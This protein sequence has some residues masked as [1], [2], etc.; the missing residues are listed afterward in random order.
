MQAQRAW[1]KGQRG[2]GTFEVDFFGEDLLG[3]EIDEQLLEVERMLELEALHA[4][5]V[6][7]NA[8]LLV[9]RVERATR[10][11]YEYSL[12]THNSRRAA[13][14]AKATT[15]SSRQVTGCRRPGEASSF[16]N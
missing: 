5:R 12:V 2:K 9:E 13:A 16:G 15:G 14:K 10:T 6:H 8:A 1:H 11:A 3:A 7:C 4:H